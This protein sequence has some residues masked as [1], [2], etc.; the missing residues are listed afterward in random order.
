MDRGGDRRWSRKEEF[1][2]DDGNHG[3]RWWTATTPTSDNAMEEAAEEKE[4]NQGN[5][6]CALSVLS[7]S[8]FVF[9]IKLK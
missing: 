7:L 9:E 2:F 4:G 3:I 8:F 6:E 1:E 5:E